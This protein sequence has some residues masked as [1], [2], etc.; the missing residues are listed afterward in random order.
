MWLRDVTIEAVA[1]YNVGKHFHPKANAWIGAVVTIEG[2][3]IYYAG[4]TDLIEEMKGLQ[5]VDV[6][7]LPIG[8][9]FTLDAEEGALACKAI[10]CHSVIPYH[11]GDI[12]GSQKD[13][14][15]FAANVDCC[16]VHVLLPGES[17]TVA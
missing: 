16:D 2:K 13:A 9:K 14:D 3:R 6:A 1:A 11:W 8:G 17:M 10:G 4:D 12:I 7:L 5:D 15:T